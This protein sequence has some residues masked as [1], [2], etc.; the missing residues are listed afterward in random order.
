MVIMLTTRAA[1]GR[2]VARPALRWM[3]CWAV[4]CSVTIY[5]WTIGGLRDN[6]PNLSSGWV[7]HSVRLFM[8][9]TILTMTCSS[10]VMWRNVRGRCPDPEA[11]VSVCSG[12]DRDLR[13]VRP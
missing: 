8:Q 7:L 3:L 6:V 12:K 10:I 13:T 9:L 2:I 11:S 5:L 1:L 4:G